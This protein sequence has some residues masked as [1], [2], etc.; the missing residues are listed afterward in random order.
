[1]FS[2]K[3]QAKKRLPYGYDIYITFKQ[4]TFLGKYNSCDGLK[5]IYVPVSDTSDKTIEIDGKQFLC[6]TKIDDGFSAD[7]KDETKYGNTFHALSFDI[8]HCFIYLPNTKWI[9][10]H[11]K[12]F[13]FSNKLEKTESEITRYQNELNVLFTSGRKSLTICTDNISAYLLLRKRWLKMKNG[14]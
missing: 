10:F 3:K 9:K 5:K 13:L 7:K 12:D 14:K 6:A 4:S 1:M 11:N 8:D 2:R